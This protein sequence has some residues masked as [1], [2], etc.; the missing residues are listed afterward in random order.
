MSARV[1]HELKGAL[2]GVSVNLEVVRLRAEK[3][4]MPASNVSR[5]AMSAASQ[6]DD[7]IDMTEALLYLS[8]A[9]RTRVELG[10][11]VSRCG[12]LLAPAARADG[13]SLAIDAA[14][15]DL[16]VTSAYGN[17]AR[18]AVGGS[19][20]A[21]IESSGDVRCGAKDDGNAIA[22]RIE[23]CDG[24]ALIASQEIVDAAATA[25]IQIVA[26]SSVISISF[27]RA[28]GTETA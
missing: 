17:A 8:R 28:G 13:R 27:P 16:G 9:A 5:F 23:G 18:L 20:L 2:N 6:L 21:A 7:V 26:E 25:G 19:L 10:V 22:I 11:L 12:A 15:S 14:I 1:A 24:S 3:P 4:E